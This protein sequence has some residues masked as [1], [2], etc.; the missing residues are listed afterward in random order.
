MVHLQQEPSSLLDGM[1][2]PLAEQR[3]AS[4]PIA[5][6][7]DQLQ[8][9]HMAF[10][11]AV[12]DPP[13][14]PCSHRLFVFLDSCSKGLEFGKL[15]ALDLSQPAIEAIPSPILE[16]LDEL[17]QQIIGQIHARRWNWRSR[18]KLSRSSPL[19]FGGSTKKQENRLS[20]K[21]R[22]A[23]KQIGSVGLLPSFWQQANQL[24]IHGSLRVGGATGH[25]FPVQLSDIVAACFPA[26]AEKGEVWIKMRPSRAWLLF[27][28]HGPFQPAR[29]RGMA[30]PNLGGLG[31]LREAELV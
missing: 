7:F 26:L 11:H 8:L 17:L 4:L 5:L 25:E 27:G 1:Q 21:H 10:H 28:E 19:S 29:D 13:G 24:L 31:R 2:H 3:K 9:G 15:A 23:R 14:E 22:R 6:S 18:S 20:C 16:H 12:I 30:Y